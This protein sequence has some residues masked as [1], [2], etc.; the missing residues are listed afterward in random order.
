M[1]E[2]LSMEL[3]SRYG[4]TGP[5]SWLRACHGNCEGTG[6][7]PVGMFV[8]QH[9]LTRKR[10]LNEPISEYQQREWNKA[11]EAANLEYSEFDRR[12]AVDQPTK[13]P[14]SWECDGWHFIECEDCRGTGKVSRLWA[15]LRI[16]YW[17]VRGCFHICEMWSQQ[18]DIVPLRLAIWCCLG[19]DWRQF[20]RGR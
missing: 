18:G 4:K 5:P 12:Q 9:P 20:C 6:Y 14:H 11:H 7:Y 8:W 19:A 17:F 16:P 10:Y 3:T 1:S 15:I 2:R 13:R